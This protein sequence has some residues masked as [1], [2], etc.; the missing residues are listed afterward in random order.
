MYLIE[1]PLRVAL[2]MAKIYICYIK[3]VILGIALQSKPKKLVNICMCKKP[4]KNSQI[5]IAIIDVHN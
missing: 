2:W 3:M 1:W 5:F 4:G